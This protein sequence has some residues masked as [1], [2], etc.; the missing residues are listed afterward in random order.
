M[1]MR[2]LYPADVSR[3]K[4]KAALLPKGEGAESP[5]PLPVLVRELA[6]P[7]R[8]CD[9]SSQAADFRLGPNLGRPL[10]EIR[11]CR[12]CLPSHRRGTGDSVTPTSCCIPSPSAMPMAAKM[13]GAGMMPTPSALSVERET[14]RRHS[15]LIQRFSDALNDRLAP[16]TPAET[17]QLLSCSVP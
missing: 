16:G 7:Q 17:N 8:G 3:P 5:W 6:F 9:N 1:R 4:L 2:Q 14:P 13:L 15:T 11:R 10:T 12:V